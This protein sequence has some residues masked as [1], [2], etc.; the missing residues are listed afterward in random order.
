MTRTLEWASCIA[1]ASTEKRARPLPR[2]VRNDLTILLTTECTVAQS[3]GRPVPSVR[4]LSRATFL[5]SRAIISVIRLVRR[6]RSIPAKRELR[7]TVST[8]VAVP[9]LRNVPSSS[10]TNSR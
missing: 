1:L 3:N 8:E 4:H 9:I 10:I 6:S 5:L 2:S 7:E